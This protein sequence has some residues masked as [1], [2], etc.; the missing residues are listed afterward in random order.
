MKLWMGIIQGIV[1]AILVHIIGYD[2]L[3]W[4]WWVL[5]LVLNLIISNAINSKKA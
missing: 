2:V 3:D 1:V 5:M 4:Q